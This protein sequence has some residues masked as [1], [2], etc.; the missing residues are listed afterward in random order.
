[1]FWSRVFPE[2]VRFRS[3]KHRRLAMGRAF[4]DAS[5]KQPIAGACV[6]ALFAALITTP[7]VLS[8][9][10]T[11][12]KR[13]LTAPMTAV[14]TCVWIMAAGAVAGSAFVA[15]ARKQIRRSLRR[16]L[17]GEGTRIC[18][19]CGYDLRSSHEGCP[20]CGTPIAPEPR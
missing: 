9:F 7:L 11:I 3:G 16:Q 12:A 13:Q 10:D 1:M 17:N 20:E 14:V 18:M 19:K 2:L 15:C 8:R 6:A 5:F 4:L